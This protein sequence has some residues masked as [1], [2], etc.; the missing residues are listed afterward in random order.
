M[1]SLLSGEF[2][3]IS[4]PKVTRWR[5]QTSF[6]SYFKCGKLIVKAATNGRGRG[7]LHH[8]WASSGLVELNYYSFAFYDRSSNLAARHWPH[9]DDEN[10]MF[11]NLV[12]AHLS[13]LCA[14]NLRAIGYM[15]EDK[16]VSESS[17]Q[18]SLVFSGTDS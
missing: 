10:E 13:R 7:G 8:R 16:F 1:S 11:Q 15:T 14:L 18:T 5:K 3:S 9:A 4:V 6:Q 12:G 2:W 17:R